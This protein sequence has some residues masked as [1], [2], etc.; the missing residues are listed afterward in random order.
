METILIKEGDYTNVKDVIITIENSEFVEKKVIQEASENN[1]LATIESL[2]QRKAEAIADI[3][4]EIAI[5][6]AMLTKIRSI[7]RTSAIN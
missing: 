5:N 4:A 3:D 7:D 2:N 6:E 1:I